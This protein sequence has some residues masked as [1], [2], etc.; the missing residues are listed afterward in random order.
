MSLTFSLPYEVHA[1]TRLSLTLA[2]MSHKDPEYAR[3]W[4]ICRTFAADATCFHGASCRFNHALVDTS[5]IVSLVGDIPRLAPSTSTPAP[6]Q[7]VEQTLFLIEYTKY[8]TQVDSLSGADPDA[9]KWR[10]RLCGGGRATL[11]AGEESIS[12][13]P[14]YPLKGQG[15]EAAVALANLEGRVFGRCALVSLTL[16]SHIEIQESSAD[17]SFLAGLGAPLFV[18][19]IYG[20][21]VY[22]GQYL[23]V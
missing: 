11:N 17:I 3:K 15:S 22:A 16:A 1:D 19:G 18:Q 12:V 13:Y 2:V 4:S 6:A 10:M 8:S 9:T 21:R 20:G 5:R 23:Q 14:T 7:A